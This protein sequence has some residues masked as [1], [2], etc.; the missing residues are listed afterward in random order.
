[1]ESV[2]RTSDLH[3]DSRS[4]ETAY[5]CMESWWQYFLFA[6]LE[7]NQRAGFLDGIPGSCPST[8]TGL[9]E[10]MPAS[11]ITTKLA[12]KAAFSLI[13][14]RMPRQKKTYDLDNVYIP[15]QHRILWKIIWRTGQLRKSHG[16]PWRKRSNLLPQNPNTGNSVPVSVRFYDLVSPWEF[17]NTLTRAF[18]IS[19]AL[20]H[21][22]CNHFRGGSFSFIVSSM[23]NRSKNSRTKAE[24]VFSAYNG[25]I[26]GTAGSRNSTTIMTA[27][28]HFC[29]M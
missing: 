18:K 5:V 8:S 2:V 29:L 27:R 15:M 25:Y 14:I 20:F 26:V 17:Y 7:E 24:M 4:Q 10:Y 16:D 13:Q 1:M 23:Q 6:T 21:V 11:P 28:C 3:M 22:R 9:P 19:E 12:A